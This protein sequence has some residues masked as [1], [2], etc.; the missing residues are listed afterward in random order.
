ME[1]YRAY[2]GAGAQPR[3]SLN[4]SQPGTWT[5]YRQ[6][7]FALGSCLLLDGCF[8]F[9]QM[10]GDNGNWQHWYDEFSVDA[11][12]AATDG[13]SGRNWLG[14]PLGA[15]RQIVVPLTN[16]NLLAQAAW[17][18][19]TN[20][21]ASARLSTRGDVMNVEVSG[22]SD[23]R[24]DNVQLTTFISADLRPGDTGTLSLEMRAS[25]PRLIRFALAG[26]ELLPTRSK[27][28]A[29]LF[30][31]TNWERR[32]FSFTL[33]DA[34]PLKKFPLSFFVGDDL[35]NLELRNVSW[36]MGGAV[37][38][39]TR[40]FE[41]GLVVVNPTLQPQ[42]FAVAGNF[43]RIRGTQD[44]AHNNGEPAGRTLTVAPCDAYLLLRTP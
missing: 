18:L 38:G 28:L 21:A 13:R 34:R 2:Q 32:I 27:V 42:D 26:G 16:P 29:P 30:V 15:A 31:S 1:P 22:L 35:G 44:A 36:Q 10:S 40:E 11:S 3:L 9:R 14:R 6:L 25:V 24:P 23:H 37:K 12:G 17:N 7:R 8:Q 39:W 5:D 33:R 41:N 20:R 4:S 19:R 43:K